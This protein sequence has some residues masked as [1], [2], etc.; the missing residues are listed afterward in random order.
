MPTTSPLLTRVA[1]TTC[2]LCARTATTHV[3]L[4]CQPMG[5]G[6]NHRATTAGSLPLCEQHRERFFRAV[7]GWGAQEKNFGRRTTDGGEH[8]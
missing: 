3:L 5:Q 2:H 4:R 7:D 8:D 6:T 1:P